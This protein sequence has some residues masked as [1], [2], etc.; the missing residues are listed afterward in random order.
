[1]IKALNNVLDKAAPFLFYLFGGILVIEGNITIGA[2]VAVIG[3][4]K[5]MSTP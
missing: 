5:D 2:L 1:M 4:H 3:A